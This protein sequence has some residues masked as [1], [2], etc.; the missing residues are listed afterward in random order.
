MSERVSS[1]RPLLFGV[2]VLATY[3]LVGL[4]GGWMW[5]ELWQ[6]S[7]GVVIDHQ[8]YADGDA[9]R[10]A[11]SGTAIYVLVAAALGVVLGVVFSF[12]GGDRP[13]LTLLVCVAG[14]L[15]ASWLMRLLGERLGPADPS[16]LALTAEDGTT[17]PSALTVSGVTPMLTFVLGTLAALGAVFTFTGGKRPEATFGAEPRG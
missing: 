12:V 15:L 5:H 7:S 3:A 6:P 10:Q 16:V 1:R 8:W 17:L 14:A 13:M 4:G 2:V 9:L 11:F